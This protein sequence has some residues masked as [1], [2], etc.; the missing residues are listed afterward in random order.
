MLAMHDGRPTKCLAHTA[1]AY[2]IDGH[3]THRKHL[4]RL[5]RRNLFDGLELND[6]IEH[7]HATVAGD[8]D[9]HKSN[10][11][12]LILYPFFRLNTAITYFSICLDVFFLSL[13]LQV[14]NLIDFVIVLCVC[15]C[16]WRTL[17]QRHPFALYKSPGQQNGCEYFCHSP[18]MRHSCQLFMGMVVLYYTNAV[19]FMVLFFCCFESMFVCGKQISKKS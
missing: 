13:C 2:L 11:R 6:K 4:N 14:V 9:A 10:R 17:S 19:H 1:L 18:N 15:M 5:V 12:Q 16:V 7:Y 3:S 8:G